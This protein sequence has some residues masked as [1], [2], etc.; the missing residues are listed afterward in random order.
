[1][2]PPWPLCPSADGPDSPKIDMSSVKGNRSGIKLVEMLALQVMGF[3]LANKS[4]S[5][6]LRMAQALCM[7]TEVWKIED[8]EESE[9]LYQLALLFDCTNNRC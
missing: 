8:F 7:G 6:R 2:G 5:P 9:I 1:M 4:D 3:A